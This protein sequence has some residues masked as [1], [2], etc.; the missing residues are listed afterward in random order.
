MPI[1]IKQVEKTED[2]EEIANLAYEI[3]NESFKE[4]ISKNQIDYM[5]DNFQSLKAMVRQVE[6]ENYNY[7]KVYFKNSLCGYIG[8]KD[9]KTELFLSKLYLKKEYRGKGI[10]STMLEK[11]FEVAKKLSKKSVY[12]TV[13][14][15]NTHAIN[16]YKAKGFEKIDSVVTDIGEGYVMDDYIFQYCL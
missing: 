1:K 15:H 5:V 11:V 4:I 12:L 9:E 13:N 16:V 6:N 8:V 2:L 14:K 7:F 10:A 3:W